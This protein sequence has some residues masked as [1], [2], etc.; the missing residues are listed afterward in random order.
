MHPTPLQSQIDVIGRRL[1]QPG[2]KSAWRFLN[3]DTFYHKMLDWCMGQDHLKTQLFRFVSVLPYLK[4]GKAVMQHLKE[5]LGDSQG[6]LPSFISIGLGLG[7]M[8]PDLFAFAVKQNV[9]EMAQLFITG[10]TVDEAIVAVKKARSAQKAFTLDILGESALDESEALDY[11]Q[12]YL[13]LVERLAAEAQ[14]WGLVPQIDEGSHGLLPKVNISIKLSSLYSQINFKAW[15]HTKAV[16]KDRIRPILERA[17]QLGVFITFDMEQYSLKALT[18]EVFRELILE[19][20]F[21]DYA[22][23]GIVLQAYLK[24]SE[25]DLQNLIQLAKSREVPF[26]VRLV[27]G[28]YWDFEVTN[29]SAKG[30]PVPVYTDKRQTDASYERCARLLL[31]NARFIDVALGSH[32]VRSLAAAFAYAEQLK[33]SNK[34]FE[35]QML[36]GMAEPFKATIIEEGYRLREYMTIGGL[37]PGMAYLVRRLLENSSNESFLRHSLLEG[38]AAEILLQ[39]PF[40]ALEKN[41]KVEAPK[42]IHAFENEPLTGF[43]LPIQRQQMEDA[44]HAF[45][46]RVGRHYPLVIGGQRIEMTDTHLS[47]NPSNSSEVVGI[48]SLA[49]EKEAL[50]AVK[51]AS[52]AFP[53]WKAASVDTRASCLERLADLMAKERFR[54]MATQVHEV[55]KPWSE[56]DGDV[57]EA[58]DFCRYYAVQMRKLGV[59]QTV[60]HASGEHSVYHYQPRGVTLVIA[61]W[62]FPLAILTG[63]TVAALVTGNTVIMKPSEDSSVVGA[64]LMEL[65]E[66]AGFPPGVVNFLPCRGSTV[67]EFLVRH[68]GISTIA[69]TGS[70]AVGLHIHE[71]A[72]I[73]PPGARHIKRCILELGGKNAM[74]I[75]NDADLGEAVASAAYS[76]VGFAGQKCSALSRAIVLEGVYDTFLNRLIERFKGFVVLPA[77]DPLAYLGPVINEVAYNRLLAAIERGK[78]EAKLVYQGAVPAGGFFVPPTIFADVP[79]D[80]FLAS[81]ELFGPILSVIK[82]RDIDEAL[83]IANNSD[84]ALTGGVFSRS[85]STLAKA[86]ALFEVGNLYLNRGITGALVDRHPFGGFKLSGAGTKAGGPDYL[87]HFMEPRVITQI[88]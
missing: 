44:L 57:A 2:K 50:A 23:F 32:N 65:L 68:P 27:K 60:G 36:Y 34:A 18:L 40:E 74:I 42:A 16:L 3:K 82:A 37:I 17:Q 77:K 59:P 9:S 29:A 46:E 33:L 51:A 28:A 11:Q 7:D 53:M 12:R 10:E 54:L 83:V 43:G 19:S 1:L 6:V 30:A 87:L 58:I 22:H 38:Q 67:G 14:E 69:F 4:N 80:G 73:V 62:N 61:P 49:S 84:Y 48:I 88:V 5:Y 76:A 35:V 63:M 66:Q 15:D 20:S 75:D 47:L 85:P 39:D 13:G 25:A 26:T 41:P 21:K 8:A 78:S 79:S 86:K 52:E 45:T 24:S 56:A 81:E 72:S 70:R 55:G 64:E 71:V 31:D